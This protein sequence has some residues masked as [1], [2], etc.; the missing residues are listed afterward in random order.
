MR[1]PRKYVEYVTENF[2]LKLHGDSRA[3]LIDVVCNGSDINHVLSKYAVTR[4]GLSKNVNRFK[5][6]SKSI[7]E[8]PV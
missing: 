1:L 6:L 2:M 7:I 8:A 3:A 4:Q 5:R